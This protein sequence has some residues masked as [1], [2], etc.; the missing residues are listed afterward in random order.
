MRKLLLTLGILITSLA[1]GSSA[2]ED[3]KSGINLLSTIGGALLTIAGL[4]SMALLAKKIM[5]DKDGNM[6]TMVIQGFVSVVVLLIAMQL[7]L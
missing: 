5:I 4:Y 3:F 1:F 6:L 7:L 2:S